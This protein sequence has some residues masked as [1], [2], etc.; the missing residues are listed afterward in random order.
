MP[1]HAL[2]SFKKSTNVRIKGLQIIRLGCTLLSRWQPDLAARLAAHL[3]CRPLRTRW[4]AEAQAILDAAV[5]FTLQIDMGPD[6]RRLAAWSWGTGPTVLLHHGWSGNAGQLAALVPPLVDA[7]YSVVAY[8]APAHGLSPGTTTNGVDM[9]RIIVRVTRQLTGVHAVVA[10]SLGCC[11]T[12]FALR[13]QRLI[14]RVVFLNPP[15]AMDGFSR[16]FAAQL[17]FSTR[18]HDLMVDRFRQTL[19]I[20]WADFRAESLAH[21]QRTPLLVVSDQDD[22]QVPAQHGK[23]IAD[24]WPGAQHAL[25]RGLGHTRIMADP[26]VAARIVEFLDAPVAGRRDDR[27]VRLPA[28]DRALAF[29]AGS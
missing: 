16:E 11:S 21:N 17:G 19:G 8:D 25:T 22:R 15:A 14:D 28:G 23:R 6:R 5:P 3:F 2:H 12:A 7:G 24:N 10:H 26:G 13:S 27:V 29:H 9:A 4:P 1:A 20:T 18:V